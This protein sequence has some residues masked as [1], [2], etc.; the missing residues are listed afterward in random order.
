MT[1][2][3]FART[4]WGYAPLAQRFADLHVRTPE[5]ARATVYTSFR[6]HPVTLLTLVLGQARRYSAI[7][8]DTPDAGW[9]LTSPS[10]PDLRQ[11]LLHLEELVDVLDV[12]FPA[13]ERAVVQ[14]L[15][16]SHLENAM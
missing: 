16:L 6:D 12:A 15:G 10:F 2:S 8:Y 9:S 13:I 3:L 11:L 5:A 4:D 1:R 14:R 7:L